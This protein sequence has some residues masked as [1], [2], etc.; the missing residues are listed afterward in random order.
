MKAMLRKIRRLV[1]PSLP[2]PSNIW[3]GYTDDALQL[4]RIIDASQG[5]LRQQQQFPERVRSV[6]AERWC[7]WYVPP[8][9]NPFYGGIMTILRFAAHMRLKAGIRQ[10]I[11]VCGGISADA[12]RRMI[13]RALPDFVDFEVLVLDSEA[14]IRQI[15]AADYGI[16][17]LWTTAYVLLGVQNCGLKFYFV[18]DFEPLFYPAGSTYGQAYASY[19]FGFH[20]I[21][22]T[23]GVL[24]SVPPTD[25][26]RTFFTPQIDDSV[27]FEAE[28]GRRSGM[29]KRL[30]C[31]ARPGHPRNAF[32]LGV[33][34]I[35][36]LKARMG[37][38]VEIV[39]AGADWR[40]GDYG[41]DGK[42]TAVGMLP[43]RDTGDLYRS[44]HAGLAMMYTR[45]P[46]Y[47]PFELMACGATVVANR[48]PANEWLLRDG[49][50]CR[51][52]ESTASSIAETVEAALTGWDADALL[53]R[54]AQADLQ[55]LAGHGWPQELDRVLSFIEG[56]HESSEAPGR[57]A[58]TEV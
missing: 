58:Q 51:L 38:T 19:H 35:I 1:G 48:N 4:A 43:F 31:Y 36:A 39:C 41:L 55:A 29:P 33:A 50:N 54:N 3:A 14:A 18:Q 8:F 20:V 52:A 16:A 28:A 5:Q 6:R 12:V 37:D 22:N 40:P 47:L 17:T 30:F 45:H 44:C 46:S 24:D 7:N 53:R 9:D 56:C 11:V 42:V 15:P 49:W 32:E 26:R 10:R 2:R 13:T 57:V 27:F 21:A 23:Q 25:T 34:A